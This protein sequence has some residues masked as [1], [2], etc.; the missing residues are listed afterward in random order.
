ML[1]QLAYQVMLEKFKI[2]K[3]DYLPI[4]ISSSYFEKIPYNSSNLEAEMTE[5]LAKELFCFS[6]IQNIK[7]L[8]VPKLLAFHYS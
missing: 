2:G 6:V 4:Y 5:V 7:E 1:L 8:L 3:S